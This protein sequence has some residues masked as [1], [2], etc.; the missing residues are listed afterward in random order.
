MDLTYTSLKEQVNSKTYFTDAEKWYRYKYIQPFS[1]R[2]FFLLIVLTI[3]A[4]F[5]GV[6]LNI[7]SL[8]PVITKVR[9]VTNTQEVD[10]TSQIIKADHLKS[11]IDSVAEIMIKNYIHNREG[12]EYSSLKKKFAYLKNNST[13]S[14]FKDFYNYMN[15]DNSDSPILRYQRKIIRTVDI[16]DIRINNNK[17]E[18]DLNTIAK[19][20]A[21][22]IIEDCQWLAKM[23][24]EI[25]QL[26]S[27]IP[28]ETRFNFAIT[29]YHIKLK[30]D[31][32]K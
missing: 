13:R 30:K 19:N 26:A 7:H 24:F 2:S 1:H 6:F 31:N 15:I 4:I 8:F 22:E 21:G 18:I 12:Y 3:S 5:L 27:D 16:K 10:K 14:V 29:D 25:D 11:T 17:A 9:Y 28:S 32:K 20:E 23:E